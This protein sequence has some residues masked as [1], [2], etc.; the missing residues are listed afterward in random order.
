MRMT[1]REGWAGLGATLLVVA[2]VG[3]NY[4]EPTKPEPPP[5]GTRIVPRYTAP[6]TTLVTMELAVED[7]SANNGVDAY[8]GALADTLTDAA[9]FRA[10]FDPITLARFPGQSSVWSRDREQIFYSNLSRLQPGVTVV[11]TW[12]SFRGAPDDD[13]QA[14]TALLYRSYQMY[15]APDQTNLV[16]IA[17]GNADLYFVL[18]G[19][20]WKLV[21]W[22]DHEDPLADFNRGELSF[23]QLRMAG[24]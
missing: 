17:R 13:H 22:Q 24:P 4:F 8:A 7:K 16:P 3:C 18:S 21:R 15:A 9:E 1:R 23:G 19:G 6:E 20:V 5:K 10:F 12:G 11:F 2:L 14:T